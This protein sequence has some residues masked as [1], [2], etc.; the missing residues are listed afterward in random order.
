MNELVSC[1]AEIKQKIPEFYF[2]IGGARVDLIDTEYLKKLKT[3][4]CF[5]IIYGLESGSQKMLDS[6]KKR[7]TVE[8]N[9]KAVMAAKEAGLHCVPQFVIG[10][11]GEERTTLSETIDFIRSIDF[12]SHL[13]IHR[14]N[15][16]PGS[17]IYQSAKEK[18]LIKDEFAY[19]SSLAGTDV[20]PLQLAD[21][22][23]REMSKIVRRYSLRREFLKNKFPV[24]VFNL[25]AKALKKVK[26]ECIKRLS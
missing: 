5:Q 3:A 26:T 22:S 7:V 21:I 8:Q 11:P 23:L 25:V 1:F 20:Y 6:M 9:R 2:R 12:W 16:Y 14:A 19:V 15:A 24:A 10:L 17:E 4:G 13:S 18:G